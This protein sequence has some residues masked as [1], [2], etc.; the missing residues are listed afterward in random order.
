M[1]L[2]IALAIVA[3]AGTARSFSIKNDLRQLYTIVIA[4]NDILVPHL[5]YDR[6]IDDINDP[7]TKAEL[8]GFIELLYQAIKPAHDLVNEIEADAPG[9]VP[10]AC[11]WNEIESNW[12]DFSNLL[13]YYGSD[14][15]Q[16]MDDK[17]AR[18]DNAI[19]CNS[20]ISKILSAP[21]CRLAI[22]W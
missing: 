11:K 6:D 1:K 3:F 20:N 8:L 18:V 22:L 7:T 13:A 15:P 9:S 21:K 10:V 19:L 16:T 5:R 12:A 2:L 17:K 4:Y 14:P